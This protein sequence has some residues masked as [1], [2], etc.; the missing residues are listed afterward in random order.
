[1][2]RVFGVMC[3]LAALACSEMTPSAPEPIRSLA[4]VLGP[5]AAAHG[6]AHG[7]VTVFNTQM[8]SALESPA[9]TS[10]SKGHAQIKVNPDGSIDSDVTINNL[11]S[12]QHNLFGL[13]P[14]NRIQGP[15]P[16]VT[17]LVIHFQDLPNRAPGFLFPALDVASASA[18]T[19][20]RP[21]TPPRRATSGPRGSA[22][23]APS[24]C[25]WP[26]IDCPSYAT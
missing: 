17:S 9:C 21:R 4:S 19:P 24:T 3:G 11:T 2:R 25:S 18:R 5:A 20:T 7:P 16:L 12:G 15:T 26:T 1:M 8:R 23:A 10:E 22:S 13:K 6:V 14:D